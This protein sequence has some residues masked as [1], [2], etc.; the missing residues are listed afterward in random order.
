[1]VEELDDS[2][3]V[4]RI[5]AVPL[6]ADDGG[7]LADEIL[8]AIAAVTNGDVTLSHVIPDAQEVS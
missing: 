6:H 3:L 1:M 5:K 2:E 4:V 7:K 8:E